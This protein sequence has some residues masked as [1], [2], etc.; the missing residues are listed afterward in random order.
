[1]KLSTIT[2]AYELEVNR[3][4]RDC[5]ATISLETLKLIE[6][7]YWGER[8]LLG[9]IIFNT[10]C[11]KEFEERN[12]LIDLYTKKDREFYAATEEA[13]HRRIKM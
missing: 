7:K 13:F 8:S 11:D 6:K 4:I 10:Q 2:S 5:K 3:L 12:E 1:M 9:R